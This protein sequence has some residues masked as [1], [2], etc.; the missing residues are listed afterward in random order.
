MYELNKKYELEIDNL[1][2]LK[3][4]NLITLYLDAIA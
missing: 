1:D 4:T 2:D 3:N